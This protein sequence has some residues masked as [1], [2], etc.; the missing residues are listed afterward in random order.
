MFS[1][2]I[3]QRNQLAT[4]GSPCLRGDLFISGVM[5]PPVSLLTS[6]GYDLQFGTSVLGGTE[7]KALCPSR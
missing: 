5:V 4:K 1:L 6:D 2:T 3:R 7:L